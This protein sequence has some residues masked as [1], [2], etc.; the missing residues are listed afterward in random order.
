MDLR[1]LPEAASAAGARR[2]GARRGG[3]CPAWPPRRSCGSRASS[4]L[5]GDLDGARDLADAAADEARRQRR[6]G[7]RDRA[8]LI[9]VEA[10]LR[11]GAA[12]VAELRARRVGRQRV[13]SV[14]G[15]L[16]S[17]VEAYLVAGRVALRRRPAAR[18][19]THAGPRPRR[20]PRSGQ[21]LR[22]APRPVG[23]RA[24][25][26]G[27]PPRRRR[28]W[29]SAVR[30][31]A[32]WRSTG[33]PADDR[34]ACPGVG[35]RRRARRDR[36][37]GGARER[38]AGPSPRLDGAHA[39]GGADRAAP[40]APDAVA[41]PR[42]LEREQDA[43]STGR[44]VATARPRRRPAPYRGV[45]RARRAVAGATATGRRPG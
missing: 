38:L 21:V 33:R 8:V 3:Q 28:R 1:L 14:P 42:A 13:S 32:T 24:R 30:V 5:T 6:A 35:S 10:R 12:G 23:R 16:H 22:P 36:P 15:N 44:S 45:G 17:A 2:R 7:W 29:P 18:R 39:C 4:L 37:R 19:G 25:G 43:S 40:A 31:C 27:R 9:G 34:A 11:A 41:Q 20:S 26:P